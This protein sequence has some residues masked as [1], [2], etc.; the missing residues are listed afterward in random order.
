MRQWTDPQIADAP[1]GAGF[2]DVNK[3]LHVTELR[4][5]VEKASLFL[6][7]LDERPMRT[8]TKEYQAVPANTEYTCMELPAGAKGVIRSLNYIVYGLE[9][10]PNARLRIYVDGEVNPRVD[11]LLR[12]WG[13][14]ELDTPAYFTDYH[15]SALGCSYL[16]AGAT[17]GGGAYRLNPIPFHNGIRVTYTNT[18]ATEA[19]WFQAVYNYSTTIDYDYGRY[20]Y[21]NWAKDVRTV[22]PGLATLAN[23]S[24]KVGAVYGTYHALHGLGSVGQPEWMMEGNYWIHTDGQLSVLGTGTEDYYLG[25]FG[26][27]PF[28]YS[29][30]L[31]NLAQLE[32]NS[33]GKLCSRSQGF[34]MWHEF[35]Q[36][37]TICGYR[38]Y[39]VGPLCFDSGFTFQWENGDELG[40]NFDPEH[41]H[42]YS[43]GEVSSS[44]HVLYYTQT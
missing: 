20:N 22:P 34:P 2:V 30:D 7:H 11:V 39:D 3:A 16:P 26:I 15:G 32:H 29:Q 14:S 13:F 9:Q 12:Q 21:F 38:Y 27:V 41:T 37:G 19:M 35:N 10:I 33:A 5:E 6:P 18:V 44:A 28:G 4:R 8:Q 23:V 31:P 40:A 36:A 17:P 25:A 24:G 43:I 42:R 1:A